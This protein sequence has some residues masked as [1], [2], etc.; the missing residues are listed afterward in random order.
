MLF[1]SDNNFINI[2]LYYTCL[3]D[4]YGK[5]IVVLSDKKA[6]E[7]LEDE[8][9]KEKV[10]ILQTKWIQML[11][12]EQNNI[13]A[14]VSKI[15]DPMSGQIQFDVYKFRDSKIKSCLKEWNLKDEQ[16]NDLPVSSDLIDSLP[17]DIIVALLE[18]YDL[19]TE[20]TE[21]KMGK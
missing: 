4:E 1:N 20:V 18:K 6:E 8:N 13:M 5:R 21:E 3:E 12:K 19:A 2:K 7:M 14:Q 10:L 9:K 17:A 11:W 15:T 16:N